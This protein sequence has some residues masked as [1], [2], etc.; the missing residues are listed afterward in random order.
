MKIEVCQ[1]LDCS[2]WY[3]TIKA[4]NGKTIAVSTKSY[5]NKNHLL[6]TVNSLAVSLKLKVAFNKS[7]R[8]LVRS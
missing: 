7:C 6:D 1:C 4:G 8:K 3:W 2:G 5:R